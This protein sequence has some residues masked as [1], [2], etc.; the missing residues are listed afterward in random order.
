MIK[1]RRFMQT[2]GLGSIALAVAIQD[3]LTSVSFFN[4]N[5]LS[6]ADIQHFEYE[7]P[8]LNKNGQL[9]GLKKLKNKYFLEELKSGHSLEMVAISSGKSWMGSSRSENLALAQERPRHAVTV[10]AFFISK[11]PITQVQ[12]A[13]VAA[14]P[15]VE[16]ELDPFPA[17][18]QG[19]LRP[20]ESISWL[21]A[22]EFCT[23]L[24]HKTGRTYQLP[25]EAQ[26]EQACRAGTQTPF[27]TGATITSEWADYVSTYSYAG[28]T[29]GNYRR[30]T[31]EVGS[32]APNPFGLHDM[33]G[34]VWE[35]C[36][37]C[38][39]P[40][41]RRKALPQGTVRA[42]RGGGWLDPPD[43]LRSASRSGYDQRGLNRTI[44]F[45]VMTVLS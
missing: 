45:R 41:Y 2:A 5:S 1:R 33:H 25:N 28:E 12:W 10:P 34:N 7:F 39:Q 30:Q 13:A 31:Q 26:W 37:D 44:G 9:V 42:I 20:V 36:A 32:F 15:T 29:T 6:L 18:F 35:W 27:N 14:L 3:K 8:S 11:Y 23:R 21:E 22:V 19:S 16:R 38:W 43:R 17:H 4:P 40:N 24:S